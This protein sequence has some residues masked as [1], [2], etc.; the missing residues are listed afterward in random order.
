[1]NL[2]LFNTTTEV[3]Q[4]WF[5]EFEEVLN[6]HREDIF[7]EFS[8]LLKN[9]FMFGGKKYGGLSV[10]D[11]EATDIICG[12]FGGESGID[13]VLG[14]IVKYIFRYKNFGQ[15]KDLLKIATYC[16][17][18]WLK[19]GF[20]TLTGHQEDTTINKTIERNTK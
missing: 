13:W 9:Q 12:M 8:T 15:E 3:K 4:S 17:I 1:M 19:A 16:Y 6:Q 14:T 11:R 18:L 7:K 2:N 10:T 20:H 5:R